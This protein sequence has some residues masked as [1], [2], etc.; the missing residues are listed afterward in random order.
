MIIFETNRLIVRQFEASDH[1]NVF[2]I[3]GDPV[4]MKYIRAPM[5]KEVALKLLDEQITSYASTPY[6]GRFAVTDKSGGRYVGNFVLRFTASINGTEIGYAFVPEEWGK[7][8]ATELTL[9]GLQYAFNTADVEK[10]LAITDIENE[11]SK[12]VLLKCGFHQ[13]PNIIEEGKEVCL[14]EILKPLT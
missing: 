8:F 4:V 14:F 12:K 7:G 1:N 5:K 3:Y 9:G 6:Y 10:V 2:A 11:L 13:L